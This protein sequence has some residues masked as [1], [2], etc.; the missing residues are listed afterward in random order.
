MQFLSDEFK[1]NNQVLSDWDDL[2]GTPH[3]EL[4]RWADFFVIYPA[5]ANVIAKMANGIADDL[6]TSTTLMFG[7]GIY[8]CPAMHEEMYLNNTTQNNLNKLSQDNFIIGSRYGDLDIGDRG[9]GRLVE[10]LDLKNNI[11]NV[12]PNDI[13]NVQN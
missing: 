12:I 3:I 9:Y 13:I 1:N 7:S 8:I 10:P 4:A 5:T 2:K 6:L 11:E